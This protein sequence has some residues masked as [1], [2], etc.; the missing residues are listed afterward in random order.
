[1][2]PLN[3]TPRRSRSLALLLTLVVATLLYATLLRPFADARDARQQQLA[4]SYHRLAKYR[5][6]AGDKASLEQRYRALQQRNALDQAFLNQS[7]EALA[8][9][10]LQQLAKQHVSR[11]G[12][13]LS[14]LQV[15]PARSEQGFQRISINLK[16][17]IGV[18]G[19]AKLLHGLGQGTPVLFVDQLLLRAVQTGSFSRG[20]ARDELDV[21]F[22]LAGYQRGSGG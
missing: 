21:S 6:L 16:L 1:M 22:D 19:L 3:L 5:Q 8:V 10:A 7:S 12:G 14:R 2:S 13:Q 20:S 15:N 4:Q 18:D 17:R 9:A 11:S